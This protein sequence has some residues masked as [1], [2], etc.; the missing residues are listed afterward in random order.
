ML[1]ESEIYG[2]D[3]SKATGQAATLLPDVADALYLAFSNRVEAM[4]QSGS[5]GAAVDVPDGASTDDKVIGMFG[6]Q[7]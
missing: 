2:W 3:L 1:V 7:P 4:R 6:R 5:D